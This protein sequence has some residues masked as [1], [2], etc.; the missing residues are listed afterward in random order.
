MGFFSEFSQWLDAMLANYIAN[1]TARIASLLQ[2]AIVSLGTLYV[3][4]WGYLHLS[5]K[6]EEPFID[7]ARRLLTL[8]L[9]LGVSLQLWLYNSVIVDTFF[10]APN[11]L[12]AGV[13]GAYDSAGI[14]DQV[15]FS[16]S[17]AASLLLKKGGL[18][19]GDFSFYLAG[20]AVYLIVGL[21][22]IYTMFLVS[23][24]KIALSILIALGPL[25][26]GLLF[27][28]STKR[29]M[30]AWIAQ[31]VNY[32]FVSILTVLTAALMMQVV[33]AAANQAAATGGSITIGNAA[34]VC[35]ASGLTFLIMKQVPSIAAGLA[36][37]VALSSFGAVSSAVAWGVGRARGTGRHLGQFSRGLTMDRE[38]TRWDSL[39]RKAGFQAQRGIRTLARRDNTVRAG[40]RG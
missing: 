36:S 13:I 7:G 30:G 8:A 35:I 3:A 11:A 29:F 38:T 15:F 21:T 2:P 34:Q 31:L 23:L 14:V 9:I 19:N 16:G 12:S 32:A 18:L 37:G 33:T 27:F 26:I 5:G 39:S 22:A 6:I 40:A 1:N 25:F 24:A 28:E 4:V 17:D 10:N 20:F